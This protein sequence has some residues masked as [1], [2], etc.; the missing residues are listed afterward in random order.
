MGDILDECRNAT[1]GQAQFQGWPPPN[2]HDLLIRGSLEIEKLR[3][4]VKLLRAANRSLVARNILFMLLLAGV[5]CGGF[6]AVFLVH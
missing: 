6:M 4:E 5:V 3:K 1:R 2:A